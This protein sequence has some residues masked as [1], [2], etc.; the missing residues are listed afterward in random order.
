MLKKISLFL[1]V[2][3]VGT[4]CAFAQQDAIRWRTTVR[5]TTAT[6]GVLT[7]RALVGEGWHL[8]GT[9]LPKGGPK[10]TVLDFS[11]SKGVKFTGEFKPSVAPVKRHD[12]MFGL[13][14]SWWDKNVTFTRP[15]CLTGPKADA[16]I[17][18]KI[19]YMGCN[20]DNCLPPKTQT[21]RLNIK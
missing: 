3:V 20:D 21:V 11:A 8:Y 19:T 16:V 12:E 18:G 17:E 6:E 7:V 9:K 13:T 1:V 2:M 10:P 15:F 14:L 5:M 4:C